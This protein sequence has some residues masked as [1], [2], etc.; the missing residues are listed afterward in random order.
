MFL[1]KSKDDDIKLIE[2]PVVSTLCVPVM[3]KT[4]A[5]E[6]RTTGQK[7]MSYSWWPE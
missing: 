5:G 7:W 3:E 2:L 4:P 6:D 1:N